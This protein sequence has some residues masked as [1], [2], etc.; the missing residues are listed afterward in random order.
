MHIFSPI[1]HSLAIHFFFFFIP[2]FP[3][4]YLLPFL[5]LPSLTALYSIPSLLTS[6]LASFQSGSSNYFFLL[7]PNLPSSS[8]LLLSSLSISVSP[9]AALLHSLLSSST[10]SSSF[11]R[12]RWVI[13]FRVFEERERASSYFFALFLSCSYLEVLFIKS[14]SREEILSLEK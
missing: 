2:S 3:H 11:F 9:V 6:F 1:L 14:I 7:E 5:S 8:F 13:K 10:S 4:I 12:V